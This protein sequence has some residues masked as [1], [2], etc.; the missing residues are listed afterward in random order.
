[1]SLYAY[2]TGSVGQTNG[3]GSLNVVEQDIMLQLQA[4]NSFRLRRSAGLITE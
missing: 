1:M 4:L 2:Q 3:K